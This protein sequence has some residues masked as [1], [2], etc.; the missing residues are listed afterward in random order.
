MWLPALLSV[1]CT[2]VVIE[3]FMCFVAKDFGATMSEDFVALLQA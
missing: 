3:L 1:H 2:T